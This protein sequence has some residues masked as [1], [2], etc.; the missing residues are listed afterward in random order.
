M[1]N[2]KVKIKSFA[3]CLEDYLKKNILEEAMGF[4]RVEKNV[5]PELNR[6]LYKAGKERN[7]KRGGELHQ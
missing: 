4:R 3:R 7:L 5:M 2:Q 6:K 1:M